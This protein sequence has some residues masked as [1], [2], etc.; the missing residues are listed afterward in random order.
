MGK[1]AMEPKRADGR[2]RASMGILAAFLAFAGAARAQVTFQDVPAKLRLYA[3]DRVTDSAKVEIRGQVNIA[4]TDYKEIRVKVY[5]NG[6]ALTP[7]GQTL[8][9]DGNTAPFSI[10]YPIKAELASYRFEI[11]GYDGSNEVPLRNADSVAAGDVFIVQGQSN[12]EAHAFD[13]SSTKTIQ[14]PYV[15]VFGSSNPSTAAG[16]DSAWHVGQGDGDMYTSANT[17]QWG[18]R[19]ARS[20]VDNRKIPVAIFNGNHSGQPIA[21]FQRNDADP[22]SIAGNYG[23]LLR[24]LRATGLSGKV[25]AIFW[26]QGENNSGTAI[27]VYK[28]SFK[29]LR[30]D[31]L[32]DYPGTEKVYMFQLRNGCGNALDAMARI[33]EAQ[34]Q[35]ALELPGM[36]IMSMSAQVHDAGSVCHYPYANGYELMGNNI[37]RLLARDLYGVDGDDIEPPSI[38]FAE[39]TG[40]REITLLMD[41]QLDT[42]IWNNGSQSEFLLGGTAA[43]VSSGTAQGAKVKLSL[44]ADAGAVA[45][46][47]FM[48]HAQAAPEPLVRNRNGV[49]ALHFF[50][51]PITTARQRDS[52]VVAA[53]LSV[54]DVKLP[55]DSVAT[56]N[57]GGRVTVLKLGGRGLAI[58]PSDIGFLDSL[59]SAE[60]AGNRLAALPRELALL[61]SVA[62]V[63]LAGNRLCRVP[64]AIG[65]WISSRA[66]TADWASTQTQDGILACSGT[67]G[68]ARG[69]VSPE[70]LSITLAGNRLFLGLPDPAVPWEIRI[71]GLDGTRTLSF[72]GG[73]FDAGLDLASWPAGTYWI[74]CASGGKVFAGAFALIKP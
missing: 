34:R 54:N 32:A 22:G 14:S 35:S 29:S 59:K 73:D 47:S 31:W 61:T 33:L 6:S 44:T 18:L 13:G 49:G 65:S 9:F 23:R 28:A 48:G 26:V 58:L 10:S 55:V 67:S 66:K 50:Q 69:P 38:R 43:Q 70:D 37:Y 20:L 68:V 51:F 2:S 52:A 56:R 72:R 42:L 21:F 36:G 8:S 16:W 63:D 11:L 57:A 3:R 30:E 64:A 19:M 7:A 74:R 17:G 25:R 1:N 53:I 27:D 41:R 4:G 62:S 71:G 46:I 45:D 60:L 24:R 5:R 39:V 40:T 15:R 12:A